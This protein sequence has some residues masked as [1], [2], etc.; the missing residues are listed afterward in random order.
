MGERAAGRIG[1]IHDQRE[2]LRV[3]RCF[4][5]IQLRRKVVTL[6]RLLLRNR[7]AV[8]KGRAAQ[9]E[10]DCLGSIDGRRLAGGQQAQ[11]NAEDKQVAPHD[12]LTF[13]RNVPGIGLAPEYG[14]VVPLPTVV[15]QRRPST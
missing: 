13:V 7:A 5:P 6:T 1:I 4:A 9:L 8:G 14:R 3:G 11:Y 2:A 10:L 15:D 12:R